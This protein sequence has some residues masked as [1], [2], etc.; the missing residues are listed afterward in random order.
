MHSLGPR[1]VVVVAVVVVVVATVVDDDSTTVSDSASAGGSW[2]EHATI[3][4]SD[5]TVRAAP[6]SRRTPRPRTEQA[7]HRL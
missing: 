4:T 7:Q 1:V 2:S 6:T 3:D 5:S